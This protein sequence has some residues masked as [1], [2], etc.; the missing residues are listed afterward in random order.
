MAYNPQDTAANIHL[1]WWHMP[2]PC[3]P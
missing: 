3:S 2:L 1:W